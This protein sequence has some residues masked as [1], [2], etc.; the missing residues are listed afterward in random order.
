LLPEKYTDQGPRT[1]MEA[2]AAGLPVIAENRDG[3]KDRVT[4]EC[5][6]LVSKH[7]EV[8]DIIKSLNPEILEKKGKAA[9]ER[10]K[11]EFRKE[12]WIEAIIKGE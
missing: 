2:M 5:G 3:A 8:I 1:I 6:W 12:K 10:A 11:K 4:E 7:E 9:R